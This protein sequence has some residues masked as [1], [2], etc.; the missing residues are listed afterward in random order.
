MPVKPKQDP[1]AIPVAS[2]AVP[3]RLAVDLFLFLLVA[4][5]VASALLLSVPRAPE[6]NVFYHLFYAS[7]Y[8]AHGPFTTLAPHVVCSALGQFHGDIWYGFHLLVAP[9][10]WVPDGLLRLKLAGVWVLT[11]GLL[12]LY[13]AFRRSRVLLP[14]LWPLVALF[15]FGPTIWR[16]AMVRP[17]V[18]SVTLSLALF[19][20]FT[21]G[22]LA[23]LVAVGAAISFLHFNY[24]WL[25]V[26]VAVMGAVVHNVV[27]DVWPCKKLLAV[28]AGVAL[29]AVLRPHP[30]A[31]LKVLYVQLFPRCW[32]GD[33]PSS[34]R[35]R[36]CSR[37]IFAISG[38]PP[39]LY[40]C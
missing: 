22:S 14:F 26:L 5:A 40:F 7:Q 20:L 21:D 31:T 24:F 12:V 34:A 35:P 10:T 15:C 17:H 4:V 1:L 28:V 39:P 9:L 25:P 8:A 13:L 2:P 19:A 16:F 37:R 27:Y 38:P 18:L 29:G 6:T 32:S 3:R 23:S 33:R 11:G 30:L 36:N